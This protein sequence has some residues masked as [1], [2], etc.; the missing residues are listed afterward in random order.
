MQIVV[1]GYIV[2]GPYGGLVWHHLQYVLGLK[3]LGHEVLF[4]ED[5]DNYPSC[6]NPFSAELTTDPSYG[7]QFIKDVFDHY[8]IRNNWAYCDSHTGTWHGLSREK[9]FS[10]CHSADIVLNISAINPLRDWWSKIPNRILIDTDPVFTQ[11]RHLTNKHDNK[12]AQYHTAFFSFGENFGRPDCSIPDDG[13]NWKPTRQPVFL[14]AWKIANPNPNAKWTTVMQWDSYKERMFANRVFGMKSLS[15]CEFENLP[16]LIQTEHFELAIGSASAPVEKLKND[17]W[18]V[19]SSIVPTTTPWSYQNYIQQSKGEWSVAK[20][21]YVSSKSGWFSER[22]TGYLASGRPVIVQDTGFSR[23]IKTGEGLLTFNTPEEAI[24]AVDK[25]NSN[26]NK[27]CKDARTIAEEYFR[28]DNV[29][30]HLLQS[31]FS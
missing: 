6:S 26:Y 9:V 18:N 17:G 12:I 5:S 25:I 28:Y 15:F 30:D 27:H 23:F 14:E 7:L 11:I 16:R 8:D 3:K 29:L 21:G 10:F 19:I 24:A 13:F 1:M 4:L 22:S 20:Q 2:R 31:S